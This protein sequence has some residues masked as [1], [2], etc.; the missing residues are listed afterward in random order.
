MDKWVEM[1]LSGAP[2]MHVCMCTHMH[3]WASMYAHTCMHVKHD[4]YGCLHGG[5]HL[6]FP[7][8]FILAFGAC[9]CMHVHVHMSRDTPP[10]P[11]IVRKPSGPSPEPQGA[12]GSHRE[13]ES[14]KVY[15]S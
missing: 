7:N 14:P 1:G 12:A 11:Q 10:C 5:G 8:M 2:P 15:K 3:A 4:K 9:A 13:P 6:Q